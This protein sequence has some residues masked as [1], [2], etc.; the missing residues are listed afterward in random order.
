MKKEYDDVREYL[1]HFPEE[2]NDKRLLNFIN[3]RV[4]KKVDLME[5][6][7]IYYLNQVS[8][9]LEETETKLKDYKTLKGLLEAADVASLNKAV[10]LLK[11][12]PKIKILKPGKKPPKVK[13]EVKPEAKTEEK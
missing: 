5:D 8:K 4:S 9:L 1:K 11:N 6:K 2:A 7:R 10:E 12:E 3:R 13:T